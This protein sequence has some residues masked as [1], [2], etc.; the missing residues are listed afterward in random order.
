MSGKNLNHA[1]FCQDIRDYFLIFLAIRSLLKG[2]TCFVIAHRLS[3]IQNTNKI[4]VVDHGDVVEQGNHERFNTTSSFCLSF[5]ETHNATYPRS[6]NLVAL[7]M[8]LIII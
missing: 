6:V 3:T 7:F 8:R 1:G 2:K 5:T 4:L